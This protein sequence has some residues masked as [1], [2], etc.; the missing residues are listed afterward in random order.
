[1]GLRL[2]GIQH[3]PPLLL[4]ERQQNF[5]GL[6]GRLYGSSAYLTWPHRSLLALAIVHER[7]S[8]RCKGG[9]IFYDEREHGHSPAAIPRKVDARCLSLQRRIAIISGYKYNV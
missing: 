2:Q 7:V 9:A 6:L 4:R 3:C 1:M 5:A 8:V